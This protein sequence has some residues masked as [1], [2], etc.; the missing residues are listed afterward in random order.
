MYTC[1][2]TCSD[3]LSKLTPVLLP[4][5]SLIVQSCSRVYE[6]NQTVK[7]PSQM[8]VAQRYKLLTLL[9][10]LTLDTV[11]TVDTVDMV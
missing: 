10:L 4:A 11:D 2:C 7:T 9:T 1:F 8:E 3:P 5:P 6:D